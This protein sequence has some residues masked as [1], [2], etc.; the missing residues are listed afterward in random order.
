MQPIEIDQLVNGETK[1]IVMPALQ[2][3][4]RSGTPTLQA[5]MLLLETVRTWQQFGSASELRLGW[6]WEQTSCNNGTSHLNWF[7]LPNTDHPVIPQNL[8]RM[9]GGANN[10]ERFEQIGQSWMK[11]AFLALE[12]YRL[13]LWL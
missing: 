7:A 2:H 11:H 9:S 13:R 10:N 1:S 5:P 12:A 3:A 4:R 8:Y 6:Q